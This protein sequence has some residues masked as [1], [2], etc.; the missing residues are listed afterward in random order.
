[1]KLLLTFLSILF[2]CFQSN[3]GFSENITWDD[4][5]IRKG[6]FY[7]KFSDTPFTGDVSGEN[8]ILK[9]ITVGKVKNG[10]PK[11]LKI[12]QLKTKVFIW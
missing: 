11:K 3:K 5:V 4:L 2:I 6:V 12:W 9:S 10:K 8:K 7:K 1:M